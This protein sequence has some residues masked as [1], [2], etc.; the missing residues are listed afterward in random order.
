MAISK[1]QIITAA[2]ELLA[3]TGQPPTNSQV[4]DALGTGSMATISPILKEWRE[5]LAPPTVATSPTEPTPQPVIDVFLTV[6]PQIWQIASSLANE[7][8]AVERTKWTQERMELQAETTDLAAMESRAAADL[9]TSNTQIDYLTATITDLKTKHTAELDE[10][11]AARIAAGQATAVLQGVNEQLMTRIEDLHGANEE[12]KT[13]IK[14]MTANHAA[15]LKEQT[16]ARFAA[17]QA[18]AKN[19]ATAEQLQTRLDEL[20]ATNDLLKTTIKDM[21]ASHTVALRENKVAADQMQKRITEC[22]KLRDDR[23]AIIETLREK[24]IEHNKAYYAKN[25]EIHAAENR[26]SSAEATA[27]ALKEQIIDLK[28]TIEQLRT[29]A[30]GTALPVEAQIKTPVKQKTRKP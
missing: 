3:A 23:I 7:L 19:K 18:V 2:D 16:T 24:A 6:A 1:E 13:T 4:R 20:H 5:T 28:A 15:E 30:T 27:T 17:E 22:N 14:D 26:A 21:T 10:E 12:F 25:A 9:E 11:I 8:L 29:P